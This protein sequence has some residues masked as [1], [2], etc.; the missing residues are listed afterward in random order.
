MIWGDRDPV[1]TL[2]QARA[3]AAEI[4]HARLEALPA[5]HVPQLG[6]PDQVAALLQDFV[7]AT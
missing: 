1:V 2:A 6:N 7:M 5:G 4:P 3:I